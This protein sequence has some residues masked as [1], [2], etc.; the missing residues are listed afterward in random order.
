[1][2]ELLL[3]TD[4][5]KLNLAEFE[6]IASWFSKYANYEDKLKSL[7]DK[8]HLRDIVV[9]M[10]GEGAMYFTND[11]IFRH[12]GLKVEVADTIGSGDAFL[13]G[14]LSN[15][16][17]GA[18]PE[19]A[20]EFASCLGA[21]IATKKGACPHYEMQEVMALVASFKAKEPIHT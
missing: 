15:L 13:A 6:L 1:V 12:Q 4:L 19:E 8:F 17:E 18:S 9:T 2:K 20:L 16:L 10:G 5:L 3:Q 21:F 7:R 11:K 14:I